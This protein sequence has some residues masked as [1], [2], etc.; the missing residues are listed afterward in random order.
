MQHDIHIVVSCNAL[1]INKFCR[2]QV[3]FFQIIITIVFTRQIWDCITV[4][5]LH[6]IFFATGKS[7]VYGKASQNAKIIIKAVQRINTVPI[8]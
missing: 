2:P 6:S 3:P 4:S 1:K 5:F 7:L 8:S